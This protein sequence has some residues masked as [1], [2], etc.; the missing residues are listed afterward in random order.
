LGKIPL[1]CAC[2]AAKVWVEFFQPPE[3]AVFAFYPEPT[4]L[5]RESI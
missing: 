1:A 5:I 2:F 4:Y 3:A